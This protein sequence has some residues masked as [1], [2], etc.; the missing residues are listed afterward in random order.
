MKTAST[1]LKSHLQ[2]SVLTICTLWRIT[3]VDGQVFGFTDSDRDIVFAGITHHAAT[4]SNPSSIKTTSDLSVDNLEVQAVLDSSTITEADIQAGLWDYAQTK[5]SIVNYLDLTMGEMILRQGFLG[6]IT[7]GRFNFIA[8][9]RG[10]MQPLQQTIGRVCGASC[11]VALGSAKCGIVL[12]TFTV[13]GSVTAVT[14]SR[15]FTDS[16]RAEAAGYFD[17]G[18]ITW[19]GGLNA[20]YQMEVKTFAAGVISLQQA[21]PNAIT[22]GD[23]YSMSAGCDKLRSTCVS[24]FNNVVNFRGFPDLPGQDAMVSGKL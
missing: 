23:T 9:L 24:K 19:T 22:L 1:A 18:L 7:T 14:S 15:I 11:D 16:I 10:M 12:A 21:M 5:I 6:N 3:R 8:E 20:T 13:T 17:G 2:G 4:G